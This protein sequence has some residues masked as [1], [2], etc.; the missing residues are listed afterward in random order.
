MGEMLEQWLW[1]GARRKDQGYWSSQQF[2]KRVV[3][4]SHYNSESGCSTWC[5]DIDLLSS[6]SH[7]TFIFICWN[8]LPK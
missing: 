3:L 4:L 6:P 5:L 1:V 2:V 7:N 8:L